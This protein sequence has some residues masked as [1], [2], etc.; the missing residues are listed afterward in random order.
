MSNNTLYLPKYENSWALVI[1]IN[2][3]HKA[4]P[5][6]YARRDAEEVASVLERSFNFP[7]SNITLLLDEDAS[8]NTIMTKFLTFANGSVTQNDRIFVFFAGHG[9]TRSGHRNEVGYLVPVDGD[10]SD[11]STLI[12]WDDLTRNSELISAKHLL[13]IM[14]ACYGGL[15][16]TRALPPGSMRFL[17]DMLQRYSRQ[18]LTA[19][20]ADEVVADAGGPRK[21]HSVFT[22]HFLNALEG[23]AATSDEIISANAVMTYVYD[24]VAKDPHSQ[25]T[26]HYGFIDGDGDFIFS[27]PTLED[28]NTEEKTGT[29]VLIQVPANLAAPKEGDDTRTLTEQIKDYLSE[30]RYRIRLDDLVANEIRAALQETNEEQFPLQTAT[31]TDKEF[32]ERLHH[33]E[34]A[35]NRLMSVV[36]LLARWGTEEHQ[37]TLERIVARLADNNHQTGGVVVWIGLRWY[38]LTLLMYVGGIAA[39]STQN[40][41]SLSTLLLT[42]LGSRFTGRDTQEAI[43]PTVSGVFDVE[44]A[45]LFKKI[46]GHERY[47]VPKSEY[48]LK[49]LQPNL[50]DLLFLGNGYED[51]FDRF[52]VFYALIY[53]DVSNRNL[54]NVWG[55]IGRFGWKHQSEQSTSP[56]NAILKEV[57]QQGADWTPFR[58]GL[59][60]GSLERFEKIAIA[61]QARL[62]G[63][64]WY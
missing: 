26:P 25:Q 58:Y 6:D 54:D 7:K 17:K 52:E 10:V 4:P 37:P 48:L 15:A 49:T 20:K 35:M 19:G 23:A 2:T 29:D 60:G 12:R 46:P 33:Y 27:A 64:P 30:P 57:K 9:Y 28:L 18:V 41:R 43:I 3:Y 16:V 1:G 63:L 59:F 32:V 38:P 56:Y 44:R 11:L 39:L 8:R 42:K 14:D 55:P 36:I 31:V 50:E 40:Y 51:L 34:K 45:D 62:N 5:L 21:G 13:F 47:Y 22:G 53:A 61:Y 24:H